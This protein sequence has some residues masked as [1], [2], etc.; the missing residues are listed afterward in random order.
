MFT[1]ICAEKHISG[2]MNKIAFNKTDNPYIVD[3]DILV[4]NGAQVTIPAGCVLLF[5]PFS[6]II[7]NGTLRVLGTPEEPVV[8]TSFN[9]SKYNTQAEQM[10]N[11]FDWNGIH[12]LTAASN[13]TLEN[14]TLTYSVYG[15]QSESVNISVV[16]GTFQR[17]GQYNFTIKD[18][19]SPRIVPV[20]DN[21]TF[22]CKDGAECLY[23]ASGTTPVSRGTVVPPPTVKKPFNWR[24]ASTVGAGVL[25]IGAGVAGIMQGLKASANYDSSGMPFTDNDRNDKYY[26]RYKKYYKQSFAAFTGSGLCFCAAAYFY[27][28]HFNKKTDTHAY[29][30]PNVNPSGEYG[31][32]ME[33]RW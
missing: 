27:F 19:S 1:L 18:Q 25:G 9:D 3:K 13:A 10:P 22:T 14:F 21:I 15:I 32:T 6:G 5:T 30:L 29:L 26:S 17:N 31:L 12:I 16:N 20:Q 33:L 7:V 2:E 24:I 23:L 11:P 4:P 28:F 8:F